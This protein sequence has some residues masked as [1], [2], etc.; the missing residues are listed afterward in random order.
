MRLLET[1]STEVG[2]SSDGKI[3]IEQYCSD[4]KE[5]IY[6]YLSLDQFRVIENWVF[7]NKD[8]IELKWNCGVRD[9]ADS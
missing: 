9:E 8:E 1:Q 4:L 3:Y 7:K 6:I 5:P 2:I